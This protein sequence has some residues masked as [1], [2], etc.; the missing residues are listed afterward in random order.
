MH[1]RH[2]LWHDARKMPLEATDEEEKNPSLAKKQKRGAYPERQCKQH[3][4]EQADHQIV[5][6]FYHK[7]DLLCNSL[8]DS[9]F[10]I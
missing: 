7:T 8:S 3:A 5:F 2:P 1:E 6:P 4:I 10:I 9:R